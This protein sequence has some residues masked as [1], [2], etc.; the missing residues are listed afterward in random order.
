M[1]KLSG[2]F[3]A[4]ERH[5]SWLFLLIAQTFHT[6][7]LK[8][9]VSVHIRGAR[10]CLR[11]VGRELLSQADKEVHGGGDGGVLETMGGLGG[12]LRRCSTEE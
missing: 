5:G 2:S 1:M 3:P 10:R 7:K 4:K 6:L 8:H 11:L 9:Y 12:V